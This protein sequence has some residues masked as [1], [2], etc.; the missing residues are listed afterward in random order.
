M[1][2]LFSQYQNNFDEMN[3]YYN[4]IL[5]LDFTNNEAIEYFD[6]YNGVKSG[7]GKLK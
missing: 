6:F 4:N 5:K 2:N 7:N 1:I 3:I